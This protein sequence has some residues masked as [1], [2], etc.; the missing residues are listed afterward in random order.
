[1]TAV[2]TTLDAY[3]LTG[4]SL[5]GGVAEAVSTA[6]VPF[7]QAW[8]L[9]GGPIFRTDSPL[10]GTLV[11]LA[12]N[13]VETLCS[14]FAEQ[15]LADN[16]R[17]L[18]IIGAAAGGKAYHGLKKDG[19]S[20]VYQ[21]ILEQIR[22]LEGSGHTIRYRALLIVHG[23]TDGYLGTADYEHKLAQ[24]RHDFEHDIAQISG[25]PQPPAPPAMPAPRRTV[26]NSPPRL[27]NYAPV[28]SR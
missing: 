20:G 16:G 27:P 11:P 24:W 9:A 13:R 28:C 18:V 22:L 23:E 10:N 12:E 5:A 8:M 6:V 25:R 7:R 15:R 4:Q 19:E 26:I 21:H 1:M 2:A 3:I 17:P 14:A